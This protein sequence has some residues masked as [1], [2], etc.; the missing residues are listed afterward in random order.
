M[1][2]KLRLKEEPRD[3]A[4]ATTEFHARA[5]RAIGQ[6]LSTL[7]PQSLEITVQGA[8]FHVLGRYVP[9]VS[10]GKK[11]QGGGQLLS[12]LRGR[13][14]RDRAAVAASE[15][16]AGPVSFERAY[17]PDEIQRLD[18]T[19]A[20]LRHGSEKLPDIYSLGEMLRM[21]GRM[22]DSDRGRL[23]RVSKD[24]HRVVLEYDVGAGRTETREFSNLQLY[25]VQQQYYAERGT[26]VPIDNWAG[27]F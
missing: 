4:V 16:R 6:D 17:T 11:A 24:M 9:R 12:N 18:E 13:L 25:K 8:S 15:S 26:Y 10:G 19:G 1:N 7:F 21:L 20:N 2:M 23:L 27:S 22:V 5:L 3:E 14:L